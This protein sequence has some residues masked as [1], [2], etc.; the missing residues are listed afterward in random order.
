MK[1]VYIKLIGVAFGTLFS[2]F[3]ISPA[4]AQQRG[5]LQTTGAGGTTSNSGTT[6]S[7]NSGSNTNN[8]GT[9]TNNNSSNNSAV[10]TSRVAP[11]VQN[12]NYA[13]RNNAGISPP[14]RNDNGGA[15]Q[16]LRNNYFSGINNYQF[17]RNNPNAGQ[18]QHNNPNG[19]QFQR[20]N[21]NN[22][23]NTGIAPQQ[24]GT[25][26]TVNQQR[27]SNFNIG[28]R[29]GFVQGQRGYY[30]PNNRVGINPN[31]R[32]GISPNNVGYRTYPALPYGR[33]HITVRPRGIYYTNRGYY[34]T[35]YAPRIGFRINVLPGSY[36]QFDYDSYQYYYSDGLYYQF[37]NNEYS[38]VEPPVG[39]AIT[40]LPPKAQSIVING[41]QYYEANGVYYQPITKDDGTVVYEIAGKDGELNTQEF[42]QDTPPQV[43]EMVE[44]LPQDCKTLKLNGKK[45]YV[46]A[47]GYYFQD[48][49]DPNGNKVYKIVGVPN[50]EPDN[51]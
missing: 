47:D 33:N 38:V 32:G 10:N 26:N 31:N 11:P 7:G 4:G 2:L 39:A 19:G 23:N 8:S 3:A 49:T 29:Q 37:D 24:G 1:K 18:Y 41:V 36:Y 12:F 17:Q 46:T 16:S 50:D 21:P 14:A 20:N 9:T 6:S 48:A 25:N 44:T 45:Y 30:N 13:P 27:G 42:D 35:Y 40:T 51:K 43:G 15:I 28:P 22:N 34:K 5:A